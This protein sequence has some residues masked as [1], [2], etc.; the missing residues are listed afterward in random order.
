MVKNLLLV[1]LFAILMSVAPAYAAKVGCQKFNFLGT[2]TRVDPP[3]DVFGDGTAVHQY[4]YQLAVSGDGTVRQYWTGLPDYQTN[5]GTGSESIG[6]W[7]CRNDG[8]LVVT[9]IFATYV[10][11][12]PSSN[13]PVP[14]IEL[15]R[16]T[17]TTVLFDVP[18]DNVLTRIQ[19][20]SRTY[21][22]GQDPTN[23]S[24]G[25][26]GAISNTSFTYN[27]FNASDADLL[28]P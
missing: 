26:L 25:T 4:I 8:K 23:A 27:R 24:G 14:D 18:N 3:L 7:T 10:P 5:I 12:T 28:L 16:H 13:A 22:A 2:F 17:R 11:T 6:S 20:R 15:F 1:S 21:T 19:A 9:F